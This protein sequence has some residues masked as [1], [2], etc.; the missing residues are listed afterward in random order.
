MFRLHIYK[1]LALNTPSCM[2]A[3]ARQPTGCAQYTRTSK[4]QSRLY[5]PDIYH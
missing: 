1:T 3:A 4:T 5:R 2:L